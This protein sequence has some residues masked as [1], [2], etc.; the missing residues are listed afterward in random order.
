M[1]KLMVLSSR[2]YQGEQLKPIWHTGPGGMSQSFSLGQ[3]PVRQSQKVY[4]L[5]TQ[6]SLNM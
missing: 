1:D 3:D 4:T 2:E 5:H 6:L